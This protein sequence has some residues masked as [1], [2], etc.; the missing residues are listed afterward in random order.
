[1]LPLSILEPADAEYLLSYVGSEPPDV[2]VIW[3]EMDR[4]WDEL[5]LDNGIPIAKQPV[6]QFYSH[7]VWMLNALFTAADHA[8]RMHRQ[9]IAEFIAQSGAKKIADFGGGGAELSRQ[10]VLHCPGVRV[11]IVEPFP[12]A[13]GRYRVSQMEHVQFVSSLEG[14]YDLIIAQDV[15]EHVDQ[16]LAI[17]ADIFSALKPGGIAIFANCFFPFIK[18][19]LPRTFHLRATF[20]YLVSL[21]GF[22]YRGVVRGAEHA[23]IFAKVGANSTFPSHVYLAEQASRMAWPL[24]GLIA[25][26][27]Q[28]I[29]KWKR[30][31]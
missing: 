15:L 18:C 19:H 5:G 17:A 20:K 4:V 13:L 24:L 31:F 3:S 12:S 23:Q 28:V 6:H 14:S 27:L 2:Q 30:R 25:R 8:S 1:M 10:I 26:I 21:G 22:E 11:D 9:A 7:P 29:R 16:P